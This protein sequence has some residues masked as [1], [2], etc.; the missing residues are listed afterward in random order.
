MVSEA[1][2]SHGAFTVAAS[3]LPVQRSGMGPVAEFNKA[4]AALSSR[5]KHGGTKVYTTAHIPIT[6][7]E[8]FFIT[9]RHKVPKNSNM[10]IALAPFAASRYA[11]LLSVSRISFAYRAR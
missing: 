8:M 2:A 3:R 7:R 6:H 1:R 4:E 10:L 5:Y 11:W 9:K